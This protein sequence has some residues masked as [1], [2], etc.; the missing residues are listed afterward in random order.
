M[1]QDF[2]QRPINLIAPFNVGGGTDLLRR[3]LAP[4]FAEA[5]AGDA[6]VSNMVGG[7][8]TVAAYAL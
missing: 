3:G 4:H 1:A 8:G 5:I 6:F 7:S 2:L